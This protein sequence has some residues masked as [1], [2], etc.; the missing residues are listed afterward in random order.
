MKDTPSSIRPSTQNDFLRVR[1]KGRHLS[2]TFEMNLFR[3]AILPF[4]LCTSL[5]VLGGSNFIMARIFFALTSIPLWDTMEP[6]NFPAVIPNAHLLGFSFMLYDRR[7][8]KV[9]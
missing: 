2:V 6:K 4:K 5:I 7:V 9:S 3:A 1:K 8:S